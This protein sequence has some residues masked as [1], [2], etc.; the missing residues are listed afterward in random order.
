MTRTPPGLPQAGFVWLLLLC[1]A[2][3]SAAV[4]LPAIIS[5]HMVLQRAAKVPVWG[6]AAPQEQVSVQINGRT[7]S[8]RADGDGKWRIELDLSAAPP[9][10]TTLAV[11]GDSNAIIVDDVLVGEVWLASG[12]SNMQK[13]LGE[14]RGQKPTF[15]AE[16][17]IAAA[18]HPDIRLFKV[19]RARSGQAADDVGGSWVR[20]APASVE[21]TKFSA[22]AYYFGRRLHTELR[23]PVGLIDSTVGG[24]RIELWTPPENL[25][26]PAQ[27]DDATLYN[28]MIAG[29]APFALKGV[30]WYQGE[31]N[32]MDTDDGPAYTPKM[33]A[34]VAG[35]RQRWQSAFPFYYAQVAPHLYSVVRPDRVFHGAESAPLL[36]EAQAQALRIPKTAMIATTDLVDDLRDIHPRDK[37][38][39]GLRLANLALA[40]SYRRSDIE[41]YGPV[42]RSLEIRGAKAVLSF[43]HADGLAARDGK[44]LDWFEIAG[45]DGRYHPASA[46]IDA[47]KVIVAS[48]DVPKPVSVRFGWHEAAQPNLV[49]KAGLPAFPFRSTHPLPRNEFLR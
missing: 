12:Q 22:A 42:Y 44:P 28:G 9:A 26:P 46:T 19:A 35:W 48:P 23:T 24:T 25:Q 15:D 40:S 17:A 37:K 31:S 13:P 18:S 47:G 39:V 29:L 38:S 27:K 34:L 49:N 30:I 33:E 2:P 21:A 1:C 41:P 8:T 3:A 7:H 36:W 14:Q 5:D 4:R 11:R 32:I 45:A 20:C 6:W 16:A 10:P 43:D